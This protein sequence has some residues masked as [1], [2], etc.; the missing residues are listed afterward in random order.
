MSY[1]ETTS[2]LS[3]IPETEYDILPEQAPIK[4]KI[5]KQQIQNAARNKTHKVPTTCF[6]GVFGFSSALQISC[7]FHW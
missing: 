7:Y 1:A 3:D 2:K 4:N 6:A 5:T